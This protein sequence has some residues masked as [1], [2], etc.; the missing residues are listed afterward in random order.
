MRNIKETVDTKVIND[1]YR[2]RMQQYIEKFNKGMT[3]E[4]ENEFYSNIMEIASLID[5]CY[6]STEISN[7]EL[8]KKVRE[9]HYMRKNKELANIINN[10]F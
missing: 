3:N 1:Y 4:Q 6:A 2:I 7:T 10:I 8:I 5:Y 9:M